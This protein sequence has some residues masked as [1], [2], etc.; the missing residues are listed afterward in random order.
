MAN[1]DFVVKAAE[2]IV[3]RVEL[4]ATTRKASDRIRDSKTSKV[5]VS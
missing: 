2:G 4:P 3:P 1:L 5:T